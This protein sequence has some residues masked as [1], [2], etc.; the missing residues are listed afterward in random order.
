MPV[1]LRG[2]IPANLLP[3]D[4]D[5]A[6]D[7]QQYRRHLEDLIATPG[8]CGITCNGHA[9]EVASLTRAEWQLALASAVETVNRKVPVICGIYA[10]TH[11]EAAELARSA[12]NTGADALLL[13]P[14]NLLMFDARR[15]VYFH[16]FAAVADV[17]DLPLVIFAYPQWTGM[18]CD[19]DL[20]AKLCKIPLVAAVKDW[21]LDIAAYE[22]N[23]RVLRSQSRHISML[24]S[25]STNLL[26]TL[27][28]GA[29]GILSGHGSV[30]ATLQAELFDDV[31]RGDIAA[32]RD[33]YS[34]IQVLTRVIYRS[35]FA[36]MHS[37]MKEQLVMLGRLRT[38]IAR[39]PLPPI[40]DEERR[41][42]RDALV[43][44]G[45]LLSL[46]R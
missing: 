36:E 43:K 11:R 23:L 18:Y 28:A 42:L 5:Y 44:A 19:E 20:L 35:P 10:E 9:A 32:A 39:P 21:T 38:A 17:V 8:V 22:R 40:E 45:L 14:P 3:F 41:N 34:R 27:I 7:L 31:G 6:I 1:E 13:F 12:A 46:E 33:V 2:V 25:F 29:D 4:E 24:S 30:I 15:D 16:R 37:R 26:P